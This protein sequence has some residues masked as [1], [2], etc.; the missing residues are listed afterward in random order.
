MKLLENIME[1]LGNNMKKC[2]VLNEHQLYFIF[3]H[4]KMYLILLVL[5]VVF[6]VCFGISISYGFT[7]IPFCIYIIAFLLTVSVVVNFD[8]SN[9]VNQTVSEKIYHNIN[10]VL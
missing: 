6:T 5:S 3:N 2:F 1:Y 7:I 10:R 9:V 4:W 8:Y